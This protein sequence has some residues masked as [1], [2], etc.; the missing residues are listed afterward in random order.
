MS[1][2]SPRATQSVSVYNGAFGPPLVDGS[3]NMVQKGQVVPVEISIGCGTTDLT[4]L[5]PHIE[6]LGGNVSPESESGS[7]TVTPTSVPS[8]DTT[9]TMRPVDGGYIEKLAATHGVDRYEAEQAA[10]DFGA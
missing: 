3:T 8:A 10:V 6:P 4:N 2:D 9:Q 5:T 1:A 7:T